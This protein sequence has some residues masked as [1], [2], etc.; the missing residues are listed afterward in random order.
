M[1]RARLAGLRLEVGYEA[2]SDE[3]EGSWQ[4]NSELRFSAHPRRRYRKPPAPPRLLLDM[5]FAERV[6]PSD[7]VIAASLPPEFHAPAQVRGVMTQ[8]WHD[9][10]NPQSQKDDPTQSSSR[11]PTPTR[12]TTRS[13]AYAASLGPSPPSP[14][15]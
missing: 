1:L 3:E 5:D 2:G 8:F 11:P 10:F 7:E 6:R 12:A 14:E 13:G 9:H 15:C 4:A